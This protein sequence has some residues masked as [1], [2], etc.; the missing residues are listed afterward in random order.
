ITAQQHPT[1][2][3]PHAAKNYYSEMLSRQILEPVQ[4]KKQVEAMYQDGA[5]IF[6][7]IGPGGVLTQLVGQI[8]QDK[9]HF[10]FTFDKSSEKYGSTIE[11][12][13]CVVGKLISLGIQIKTDIFYKYRDL[14]EYNL[15]E[16]AKPNTF[17]SKTVF[18][19]NGHTV[20]LKNT[21]IKPVPKV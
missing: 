3:D 1:F 7:E 21:P 15:Q 12:I 6:I 11:Q 20:R 13:F 8:L 16:L 5:R 14:K 19:V 4:F 18:V 2:K 10:A 9:E 17:S